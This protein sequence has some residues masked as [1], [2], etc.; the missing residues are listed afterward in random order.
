[1]ECLKDVWKEG[2]KEMKFNV[3]QDATKIEKETKKESKSEIRIGV[4]ARRETQL[5]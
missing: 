4:R 3:M 2:T 1:M 5:L